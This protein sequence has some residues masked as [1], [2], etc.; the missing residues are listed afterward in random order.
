MLQVSSGLFLGQA[1]GVAWGGM[2][3]CGAQ[4]GQKGAPTPP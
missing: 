4:R 1:G 3:E 2:A